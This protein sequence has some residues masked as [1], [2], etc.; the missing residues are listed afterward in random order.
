MPLNF[1]TFFIRF[2]FIW[3]DAV[4]YYNQFMKKEKVKKKFFVLQTSKDLLIYAIKTIQ[5]PLIKYVFLTQRKIKKKKIFTKEQSIFWNWFFER[6]VDNILA[7]Y[8]CQKHEQHHKGYVILVICN[9]YA[10]TRMLPNIYSLTLLHNIS[11]FHCWFCFS[12]WIYFVMLPPCVLA[13]VLLNVYNIHAT[14]LKE[15]KN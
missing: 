10:P 11:S 7:Q 14:R 5:N 12:T 2:E 6:K 13:K 8:F 9:M 4:T 15:K 3:L 1:P